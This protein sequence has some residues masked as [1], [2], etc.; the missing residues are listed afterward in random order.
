MEEQQHPSEE[1]KPVATAGF[2]KRSKNRANVRKR[3]ADEEETNAEADNVVVR[4]VK[5]ARDATFSTKREDKAENFRFEASRNIQQRT[6]QGATRHHDVDTEHDRDA[7]YVLL[8]NNGVFA[9][10]FSVYHHMHMHPTH[11]NTHP[12]V[13]SRKSSCRSAPTLRQLLLLRGSTRACQATLTLKQAFVANSTSAV[14]K[15]RAP[16]V[17]CVAMH[18]L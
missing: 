1:H 14:T 9:P 2:A 10:L 5:N 13:Q 8:F 6:D 11:P 18:S 3:A 17:P 7:R 4:K 15:P 16:M 12:T